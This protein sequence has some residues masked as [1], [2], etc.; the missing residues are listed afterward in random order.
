MAEITFGKPY[1]DELD[2]ID[3]SR[4]FDVSSD[5]YV[6]HRDAHD[7]VITVVE[8]N[9]WQFQ[10]EGCLPFLLKRGLTFKIESGVYHRLI[11]G[12]DDLHIKI[13]ENK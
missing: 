9:G 11:K 4:K 5:G 1:T 8:G 2:D 6:W 3:V 7:R 13:V 10:V 12:V